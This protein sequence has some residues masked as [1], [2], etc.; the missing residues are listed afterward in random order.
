M[1]RHWSKGQWRT[2]TPFAEVSLWWHCL[3]GRLVGLL[4]RQPQSHRRLSFFLGFN[5]PA[6][7]GY[8]RRICC[9]DCLKRAQAKEKEKS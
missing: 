8:R 1:G 4:S 3:V 5:R 2:A 6:W 9:H 7:D